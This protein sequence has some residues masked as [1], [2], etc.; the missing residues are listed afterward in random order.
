MLTSYHVSRMCS[1]TLLFL[2]E[3][4]LETSEKRNITLRGDFKVSNALLERVDSTRLIYLQRDLQK[5]YDEILAQEEI[6]W[7]HKAKV[8]YIKLGDHNTKFF[9]TQTI[10]RCKRNK[11]HDLHIA[12][13][14]WCNVDNILREE[15]LSF[16]K[17]FFFALITQFS[18]RIWKTYWWPLPLMNKPSCP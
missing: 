17:S 16:F 5:E 13:G 7:Y 1:M 12:N 4:H 8:D 9:H 11:I 3:K 2:I 6:H 10:I 14:I 18:L 15:A